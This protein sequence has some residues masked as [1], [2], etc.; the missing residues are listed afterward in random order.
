MS[1]HILS[2]LLNESRKRDNAR[3]AKPFYLFFA[4]ILIISIIQEHES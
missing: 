1:G 2:K 3:L 4:T